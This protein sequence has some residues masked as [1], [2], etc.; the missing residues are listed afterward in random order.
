MFQCAYLSSMHTRGV[1][2]MVRAAL[3]GPLR[4]MSALG[5]AWNLEDFSN[6][7]CSTTTRSVANAFTLRLPFVLMKVTGAVSPAQCTCTSSRVAGS[8]C[9]HFA[10][11]LCGPLTPEIPIDATLPSFLWARVK[12]P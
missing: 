7:F 3:G 4:L 1:F 9:V 11:L 12:M 5:I 2:P 6:D 8:G 10:V